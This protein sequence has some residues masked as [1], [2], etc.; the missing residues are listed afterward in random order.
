M[1]GFKSNVLQILIICV[2][3]FE[4]LSKRLKQPLNLPT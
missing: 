4:I 1:F 2:A 3:K